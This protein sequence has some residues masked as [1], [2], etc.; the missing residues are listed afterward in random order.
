MQDFADLTPNLVLQQSYRMGVVN[1]SAR[2]LA[3]PQ[4][5]D[6]PLVV[7]FD[8]V[9]APA[10]DFINQ[11][12]FDIERIEVLKGPQG[13]LYGAGA[14]GGA[15]NI[16]TKQPTN[17]FDAFA[18][19]RIGN[20]DALRLVGGLS[21]PILEDRLF[22]RLAGVHQDR[23]G[24]IKNSLTGDLL[25]FLEETVL[26]GGLFFSH[27]RLSIDARAS[28][29]NTE[30]GASFYESL[31]LLPDPVPEIDSLFGGPL[32]RLG[33]DLSNSTFKNHSNIQTAEE[34]DV[35][36]ASLKLEFE[37]DVG[38][39]TSVTGYN[40]SKQY[41]YGDL[42]FQPADVLIQDVRFD[43]DVFNQELRW[44]SDPRHRFRW[45]AGLFYQQREIFNQVLVVLGD[46]TVGPRSIA[47]SQA[48]PGNTILTD[49]RDVFDSEAFGVFL[50]TNYDVS[51]SLVLT[52]AVRWDQVDMDTS[53][54]GQD[55]N[56]INIP[57]ASA[58]AS[59]S[60]L[61]PKLNLAYSLNEQVL[62]YADIARGFRSGVPNPTSAF[63][64]GLPRFIEPEIADTI[65]VGVKS[66]FWNNRAS[67]NVAAFRSD[68]DNRHH[69]F[70][71]AA[72][73]SMT[74]YDEARVTGLEVD[75]RALVSD[76][77]SLSASLGIMDAQIVSDEITE[78]LD[79]NTGEVALSVNNEGNTLPDTP[80]AS[81][82]LSATYERQIFQ[83]A[84]LFARA[85]YRY[86]DKMYFDTENFIENA[87]SSGYVDLR[88][89]I[90][91]ERWDLG[92][93]G[94]NLTDERNYS[95][96]AYSGLQ[97]NYLPNRP[98][99]YGLKIQVS[100]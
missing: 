8:G 41:D 64:G 45:V 26:R 63:A 58:S 29:T 59:F 85:A 13:A 96:Y 35:R 30:A 88:I 73:Q 57:N 17:E 80:E 15:I 92:V 67:L 93:F 56:L 49:T 50:S 10:Q 24:Y 90:R 34:R 21:G 46:F 48:Q 43:V 16:I 12:L 39:F 38:V 81:L 31:P 87:G 62:F 69:Y 60:K 37:L 22:Y 36:T 47:Q 76:S 61:L 25:D 23:D 19:L 5:G 55:P 94:E 66:T 42:D 74:T 100:L 78:Y 32:G 33:S 72:L 98:K 82:N 95:N 75:F 51:D 44:A 4:Q 1:I 2:G 18:K 89:G 70:Y 11:D 97:G 83:N 77:L 14:I 7:N 52:A 40:D 91:G 54:V 27:G 71:G 84:S 68:V 20:K 9:Q 6:S 86:V 53:Y 79:V 28:I 3:T 99:V 65:E